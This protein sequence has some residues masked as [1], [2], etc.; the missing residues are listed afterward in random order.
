MVFVVRVN[1]VENVSADSL[2]LNVLQSVLERYPSVDV[3]ACVMPIVPDVVIVPPVNGAEV[4]IDVTVPVPPDMVA[5]VLSPLRYVVEL[6]VPVADKLE[7]PTTPAFI[8][9][10][11]I[12]LPVP[13]KSPVKVIFT[14]GYFL[15]FINL[16]VILIS[17]ERYVYNISN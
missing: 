16:C 1:P 17:L 9:V 10:L 4:P 6:G 8:V 11:M 2:E 13:L 12:G 15:L 14:S 7:I 5:H 3:V